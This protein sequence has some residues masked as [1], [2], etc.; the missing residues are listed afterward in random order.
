MTTSSPP[1]TRTTVRDMCRIALDTVGLDYG[2]TSSEDVRLLPA[3]GS[4]R[5][6]G[7]PARR[8]RTWVGQEGH[9][10]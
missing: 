5:A 2:V 3:G 4:R 6:L 10:R 8:G 9:P 1:A 7:H